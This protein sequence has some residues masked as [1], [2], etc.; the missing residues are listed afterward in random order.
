MKKLDILHYVSEKFIITE[1]KLGPYR[2]DIFT[3]SKALGVCLN[4]MDMCKEKHHSEYLV[5][6]NT[7]FKGNT[8][9]NI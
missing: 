2:V 7:I 1:S 6:R 5:R 8:E 9:F 3:L 4:Q